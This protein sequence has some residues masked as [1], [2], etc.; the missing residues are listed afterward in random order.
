MAV[1]E[2]DPGAGAEPPSLYTMPDETHRAF[3]TG[4]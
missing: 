4:P 3:F 1:G 2:D